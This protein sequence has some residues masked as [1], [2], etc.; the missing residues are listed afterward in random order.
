[1][2]PRAAFPRSLAGRMSA[3]VSQP[4]FDGMSFALPILTLA[5]LCAVFAIGCGGGGIGTVVSGEPISLV[6]LKNVLE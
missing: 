3:N 4:T 6:A 2:E 5:S 1:M